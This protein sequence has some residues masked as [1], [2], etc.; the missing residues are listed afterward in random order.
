MSRITQAN[1]GKMD[2][3]C[4]VADSNTLGT[5]MRSLETA[6]TVKVALAAADTA[7]GLLAWANPEGATIIVTHVVV[8]V[9]TGSTGACTADFGVAANGTTLSDT[10]LDGINAN[11][12]GPNDNIY[13]KGTAGASRRTMTSSQFL[14]GSKATGAAAGLVGNAYITYIVA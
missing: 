5:R 9:T 1:A 10:L 13:D 12:A 3:M 2:K 8:D 4:P 14:T 7:G 11:G 6:N